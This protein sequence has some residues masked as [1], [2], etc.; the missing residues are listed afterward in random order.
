MTA[1][2]AAIGALEHNLELVDVA[3]PFIEPLRRRPV[4]HQEE[5]RR[6]IADMLKD[7]IIEKSQGPRAAAYV[8]AKNKSGR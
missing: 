2:L 6:Q 8:L 1:N 5:T 7:G 4:A 3:K